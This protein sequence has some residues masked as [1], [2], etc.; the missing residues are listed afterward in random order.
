MHF[1]RYI[2]QVRIT[3]DPT[4][5]EATLSHRGLD[6]ADAALVFAGRHATAPDDR[7]DYGEPRFITAGHL[8]GRLV[9]IVWT[10]RGSAR[11]IISMRYGHA[12]EARRW[13]QAL[14]RS[15]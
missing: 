4:K 10:P 6:F 3:F 13:M 9:V 15:R 1:R 12:K 14:D 2:K 7:R 5:R 8:A 11:R